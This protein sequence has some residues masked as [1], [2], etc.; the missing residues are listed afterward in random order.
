MAERML[1]RA[2]GGAVHAY[3]IDQSPL[4]AD[5]PVPP[6]SHVGG[7]GATRDAAPRAG[8]RTLCVQLERGRNLG[9]AGGRLMRVEVERD[10]DGTI[11][12]GLDPCDR[13]V[14][15]T[16]AKQLNLHVS[17]QIRTVGGVALADGN[18]VTAMRQVPREVCTFP[19]DIIRWPPGTDAPAWDVFVVLETVAHAGGDASGVRN[20]RQLD[21]VES[22]LCSSRKAAWKASSIVTLS[23]THRHELTLQLMCEGVLRPSLVGE[24]MLDL[25]ALGE[26]AEPFVGWL[27][28]FARA[29]PPEQRPVVGEL[30]VRIARC[31]WAARL[32]TSPDSGH[33][34]RARPPGAAL[35]W[36]PR[37][38]AKPLP[39]IDDVPLVSLA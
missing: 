30:L 26:C 11:G 19:V 29:R 15:V 14:E 23:P 10:T 4:L 21:R 8:V 16:N 24:A 34:D 20:T 32:G 25:D 3:T 28:L 37:H 1:D 5:A 17:D 22:G 36:P 2:K 33:G 6:R 35:L 13:I 31:D 9:W 27:P 7:V 38:E 12:I 39:R 18:I